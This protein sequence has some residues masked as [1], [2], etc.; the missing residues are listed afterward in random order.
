LDIS[1]DNLTLSLADDAKA[2]YLREEDG[3][4]L[5]GLTGGH[6]IDLKAIKGDIT[7]NSAIIRSTG[8]LALNSVSGDILLNNEN[9]SIGIP[10]TVDAADTA[11]LRT[12]G[13]LQLAKV[14][15]KDLL[16]TATG[17]ITSKDSIIVHGSA[18]FMSEED[19]NIGDT[20]NHLNTVDIEANGDVT[21]ASRGSI[22]IDKAV[23]GRRFELKSPMITFNGPAKAETLNVLS[24]NG[25]DDGLNPSGMKHVLVI[26]GMHGRVLIDD[27]IDFNDALVEG[28][29]LV[30]SA[31]NKVFGARKFTSA[32]Q[33]IEIEELTEIDPAIFTNVKNY[34]YQDVS[35]RLPSDQLYEEMMAD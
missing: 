28:L 8:D 35:I 9:N 13:D 25:L 19:I 34:V 11:S 5:A 17:N 12:K 23:I 15:A 26:V 16:L 31:T 32:D 29:G 27:V 2:V 7:Q 20:V 14:S 1:V 3:V 4:T 33:M 30:R 18:K 21:V 10:I 6:D 22:S 24:V